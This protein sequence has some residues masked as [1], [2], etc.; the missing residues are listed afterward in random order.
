MIKFII[1]GVV[2]D[3]SRSLFPVIMVSI[4]AFLT[5]AAYSW[6]QGVMGDMV[7]STAEFD[8]GHV[9]VVTKA[10]KELIDQIPNDLAILNVDKLM[11]ELKEKDKD[12]V[13]QA[14]IRFG[15]MLDIP[16]KNGETKSQ[17]P[18]AGLAINILG[19]DSREAKILDL[20][21][22]IV[23][24]RMPKEESEILISDELAEKLGV[25]VGETAT[26][27]GSTMN[28][29][30]AMYN[31]RIAGTIKFGITALDRSFVIADI[32]GVRK[33][34]D[35]DN[36]ASEI[37]GYTTD[38]VY[39]DKAMRKLR[40]AFNRVHSGSKDRFSPIMLC[41]TDQRGMD[42]M[43]DMVNFIGSLL[44]VVFVSAMS[45]V[46]WNAGLMNSIRR[47]GEIGVRLAI[48]ESKGGIYRSM[49]LESLVIGIIGSAI[50]SILGLALSYYLQ[51][52]GFNMGDMMQRSNLL[53]TT[54]VRAR[55]DA[56]S[57]FIGFIPGVGASVIGTCFAG[58]GIYRRQTSQLFKELES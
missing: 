3:K 23:R 21:K 45:I 14:R 41:L 39:N 54:E 53:F 2:R 46:L 36:A 35:M 40:D 49:I 17:A 26:L 31:F 22:A 32:K 15:G 20:G 44:V 42:Q 50:G 25:N 37:V 55:V 30:M 43:V 52:I 11:W 18:I 4:G 6:I 34:L 48:G 24:G 10:Y 19:A 7:R 13:W 9:K 33:A 47:Y 8:T 29:S 57:Y 38:Y 28:G 5:V 58:I 27:L 51:Y 56:V 12:M 1:K 16:D